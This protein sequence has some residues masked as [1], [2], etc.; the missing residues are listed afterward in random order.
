M[1]GAAL[2]SVEIA[3]DKAYTA[4]SFGIPTHAWFDFIKND[5]PLLRHHQK[6]PRLVVSAAAIDQLEARS[7]GHRGDGGHHAGHAGCEGG[8]RR[9]RRTGGLKDGGGLPSA[10]RAVAAGWQYDPVRIDHSR[11]RSSFVLERSGRN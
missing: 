1:D 10:L 2:L 9:S 5:P 6:W 11:P 3:A 8:S 7:P 4:I